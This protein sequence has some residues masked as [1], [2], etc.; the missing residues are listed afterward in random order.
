MI[1]GA[2]PLGCRQCEE[3]A[4]MVLFVTGLCGFH[5]FY[6]PVS[7][8]KMYTDVVYAD[9]KRVTRDEDVLEEAR[10]IRAKGAGITGGDPLVVT[11]RT[12][13]YI[14]LLKREFGPEF[15]I[16]LYTMTA[17]PSKVRRLAEAGL[18]ELRFHVPPGLWAR[19]DRSPYVE[20]SRVARG[21]GVTVGLEVPLIPNR[22][23]ELLRLIE[24]AETEGL[25]FVN[26]NE[27]EFSD[28]NYARMK[29]QGYGI[30]HDLS[31]GVKGADEAAL[32][33]LQRPWNVT[34]HYCTSGYKDGWQLRTRIQRRAE[35][36]ARP[37]DVVTEDGTL[38]KGIVEGEGL[39]RLMADLAETY[40]VPRD[41]M[42]LVA[43]RHRLEIAP[44]VLEEIAGRIGR[45]SFLVEEYPTSD[46]LEVERTRLP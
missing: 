10:A 39:D 15:H 40:R 43:A 6:C 25:A 35:T 33:I 4:K 3:G 34:V 19:A 28:A 8:E 32:E 22:K 23:D 26:L 42:A 36:V 45:P 13:H 9:E 2:L 11:D 17:D 38:L 7:D 29:R 24:W 44:W 16:H 31:Y 30:K 5:C 1:R 18:D 46:G 20:A 21:L 37:W 14:R 12:C 27:L 41:L